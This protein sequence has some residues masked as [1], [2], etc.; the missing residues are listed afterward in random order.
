[1]VAPG[2]HHHKIVGQEVMYC[3]LRRP[4]VVA[5]GQHHHK[6]VGQEVMYCRHPDS[7]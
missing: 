6:I 4:D 7:P 3:R 1:V 5:P 2:Q